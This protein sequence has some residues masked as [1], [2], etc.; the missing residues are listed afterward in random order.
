[1][2]RMVPPRDTG[3]WSA[4]RATEPQPT[5][6]DPRHLR[7]ALDA[8]PFT[9]EPGGDAPHGARSRE[10]VEHRSSLPAHREQ[11]LHYG[12]GD[13]VPD[14]V[15]VG[16]WQRQH[17]A[18]RRPLRPDDAPGPPKAQ[19]I[20]DAI[21]PALA[22]ADLGPDAFGLEAPARPPEPSG[23]EAVEADPLGA[24]VTVADHEP[25]VTRGGEDAP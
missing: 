1:M 18:E 10:G 20:V 14:A 23:D 4:A 5:R 19:Q 17:E 13:R 6:G 2:A 15:G 11:R 7:I 9:A 3:R 16:P 24:V 8:D 22:G 12:L 21:V 25:Q